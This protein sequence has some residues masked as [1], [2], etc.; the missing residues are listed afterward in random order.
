MSEGEGGTPPVPAG[1]V[2]PSLPGQAAGSPSQ[3]VRARQVIVSGPNGGV[4]TYSPSVGAGNL[5]ATSGTVAGTDPYGNIYLA[6]HSVYASGFAA[7]LQAGDL[8]F[9]LGSLAA[10]WTFQGDILISLI[11]GHLIFN[12]TT[13]EVGGALTVDGNLTVVGTAS[14]NGSTSVGFPNPNATSTNGLANGQIAGTSGAA[15]AG[16]AHTHGPGSYAVTSGLHSHDLQNHG[17]PL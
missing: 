2:P 5:V 4:F 10:G 3:I 14:I 9:Y 16:T 12:F 15:S 13:T 8:S 1:Y 11:D 6:G 17:H 7:S